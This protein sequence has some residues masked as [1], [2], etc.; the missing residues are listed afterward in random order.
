[1]SNAEDAANIN[2]TLLPKGLLFF[3]K[4]EPK[5]MG[6]RESKYRFVILHRGKSLCKNMISN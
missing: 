6:M 2:I 4:K 1:M 5:T 3:L